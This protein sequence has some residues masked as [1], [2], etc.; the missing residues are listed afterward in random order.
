LDC[1]ACRSGWFWLVAG[2]IAG[3]GADWQGGW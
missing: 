1:P 3:Y 2:M